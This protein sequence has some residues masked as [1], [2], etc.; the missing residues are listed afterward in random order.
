[1]FLSNKG[2][3]VL[4]KLADD[5]ATA[6]A[7]ELIN[8]GHRAT[9]SLIE[10]LKV[11]LKEGVLGVVIEESHL[12]YGDYVDQGRR[13]GAR[14]VPIDAL[15]SWIQTRGIANEEKQVRSIAYAIQT[16]IFREGSPTRGA[17]RFSNNGRRTNWVGQVLQEKEDD[18]LDAF[19][20]ALFVDYE[21]QVTNTVRNIDKQLR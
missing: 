4:E 21:L 1:M 6:L 14:K 5:L 15:M 16:K 11:E 2:K 13:A 10:S 7:E 20:E 18:I 12:D 19:E 9:G 8:Q 17:M 3:Q